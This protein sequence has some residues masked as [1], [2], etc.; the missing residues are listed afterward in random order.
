MEEKI[1][2]KSEMDKKTKTVMLTIMGILLGL[3]VLI[4]LLLLQE[5][6]YTSW[7][8][9]EHTMNGYRAA[10][11]GFAPEKLTFFIV[12]CVYFVVGIILLLVFLALNK[13][14][15]V[16]TDKNAKGKT[17]FGKEIVLPLYMVSAY[18]TRKFLSTIAVATSSGIT[19][20]SLIKNYAEIGNVLSQKINER[21][22]NTATQNTATTP[23][24]PSSS[25]MD[26]LVKLKSL[27]DNGIITQEEFDTKKKQ[28]LGL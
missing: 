5:E 13:C 22:E 17:L 27:L 9:Y 23:T 15:L 16:I 2:I 19:K 3:S 21:Q 1:L 12:A 11:N 20:F 6:T 8:G 10:F 4:F 24:T 26:D 7:L 18:T 28:I 25:S 14:T